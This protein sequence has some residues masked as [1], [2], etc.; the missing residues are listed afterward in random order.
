MIK[1]V[2]ILFGEYINILYLCIVKN[3]ML[4]LLSDGQAKI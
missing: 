1:I 3:N 2:T 4:T